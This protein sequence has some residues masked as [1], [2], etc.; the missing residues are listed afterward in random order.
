[1]KHHLTYKD[2]KSDK[3]WNIEVSGTSFTVTY[4][5]TGTAGQTSVKDF[6]TEEK[7]LKEAE[8]LLSEKL[9]KGY[10]DS[11]TMSSK[12]GTAKSN[13]LPKNVTEN[14]PTYDERIKRLLASTDIRSAVKSHFEYLITDKPYYQEYLTSV[15]ERL[16]SVK[17]IENAKSGET[18][19]ELY[20]LGAAD[21]GDVE[22][23]TKMDDDV[24]EISGELEPFIMKCSK[25]AP[26]LKAYKN[27]PK[28][29]N[30]LM[31]HHEHIQVIIGGDYYAFQLGDHGYCTITNGDLD[32]PKSW[33]KRIKA[34]DIRS[35]LEMNMEAWWLYYP[36]EHNADG[37]PSLYFFPPEGEDVEG[38]SFMDGI[39]PLFTKSLAKYLGKRKPEKQEGSADN[40]QQKNHI[41]ENKVMR[42]EYI[43]QG[44]RF[45]IERTRLGKALDMTT[46]IFVRG[47]DALT[48]YEQA[49]A[50]ANFQ[51]EENDFETKWLML[52]VAEDKPNAAYEHLKFL[53]KTPFDQEQLYSI[54]TEIT[55][56]HF[57]EKWKELKFIFNDFVLSCS[58]PFEQKTADELQQIL[59]VHCRIKFGTERNPGLI[60]ISSSGVDKTLIGDILAIYNWMVK[61]G[62]NTEG[63]DEYIR[64]LEVTC[65]RILAGESQT[66]II[67]TI[68]Y[69]EENGMAIYIAGFKEK[70]TG[71]VSYYY[72][73]HFLLSDYDERKDIYA[74]FLNLHHKPILGDSIGGIFIGQLILFLKAKQ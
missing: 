64:M 67:N 71:N 17:I 28:S 45:S 39:G 31:Q 14:V 41:V 60:S 46:H 51:E 50:E 2:D 56:I 65:N 27:W 63:V 11:V 57:D 29:F 4:G 54:C 10:V 55:D 37:E 58:E 72:V 66:D 1:M 26:N 61:E 38:N 18:T 34:K 5:K 59:K 9:K 12:E 47:E 68:I 23:F 13:S 7:C 25:P 69:L 35:P 73:P 42:K 15:F 44:L 36:V 8:K 6:D 33:P 49:V 32:P 48:A 70:I 20:F 62:K 22:D 30:S 74:E 52:C 19:L 21:F 3:F 53:A 43:L 40:A 24:K 16:Q